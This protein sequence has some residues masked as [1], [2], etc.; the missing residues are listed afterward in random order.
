MKVFVASTYGDLLDYREA[1]TRA[2][3]TTGNITKDMLYWPAEELPPL[4]VS[5]RNLR[6][7]NLVILLTAHRYGTPPQGHDKSITE[8]EFDEAVKQRIPVLAFSVDRKY[9]WS[10]D[11][12]DT[13]P[14]ARERLDKFTQSVS[15][16]VT[17]KS[18]TSPESLEVAITYALTQFMEQR[19]HVRLPRF[20]QERL[21]QVSRPESLDHSPDST[22]QIGR[23]P[24][25]APLL[26]SV[27][28]HIRVEEGLRQ[29]AVRMGKRLD[30]PGFQEIFGR[31]NQE[32]RTFAAASGIHN[33]S[34]GGHPINFYVTGEPLTSLVTPSLFQAMIGNRALAYSQSD[35]GRPS[36]LT[37]TIMSGARTSGGSASEITSLGGNNR[38]LCVAL[39]G[40]VVAWSGGWTPNYPYTPE[41][42][43][44]IVGRPF[45]EEGLERLSNVRYIIYMFNA[46][47]AMTTLIDTTQPQEFVAKWEEVLSSFHSDDLA[48][49]SYHIL[50]PR[51]SIAH[52]VLE[53]INEVADLHDSGQIHGD[54]KPSNILISRNA[55]VLIDDVG[56]RVND[57]S[58]SVTAGW[59]PSEQL[60]R[61]PLSCAADVFSLGQLLL[62]IIDAEPLGREVRFRLPGGQM[63]TIFDDPEVYID[64]ERN[65]TS[66]HTL[67]RWRKLIERALRTDPKHRWPDARKMGDEM[68]EILDQESLQGDVSITL[69]WGNSPSLVVGP[70]GTLTAGWVIH[71]GTAQG[72][73]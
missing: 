50:V 8:L 21:V 26:L 68:R 63:A 49:V 42:R 9:R 22:V 70:D 20:V 27:T 36:E 73:L 33:S 15:A 11:Q 65:G 4:E 62:H 38:F 66:A 45:I 3:V 23:A 1:A 64:P 24:D 12:I 43:K 54:I 48:G 69:P 16:C 28:R 32:A 6:S 52:F 34:V 58:P 2:I 29:I 35:T 71:S 46:K 5:L 30:D 44:L 51:S 37:E 61:K 25:G 7:S 14:E 41:P 57:I 56:L 13:S 67:D 40:A 53:V 31:L 18:F 17:R 60:L 72:L 55:P 39:D 59:S 19:R 47:S 10:P